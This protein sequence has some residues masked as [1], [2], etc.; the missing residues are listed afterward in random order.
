GR[1]HVR[2]RQAERDRVVLLIADFRPPMF[3]GVSRAFRSVAAAEAL[4]LIGWSAAEAGGRV[5]LLAIT[6]GEAA[7][8]RPRGRARGMLDAI[9]AMVAAHRA[10]LAA[11]R[12]GLAETPP[13][14][15]ALA[16][17]ERLAPPGAELVLA[18]GFDETGPELRDR[19]D[20][21]AR[22]RAPRLVEV[23]DAAAGALPRGRYPIRLPGGRRARVRL[24]GGARPERLSRE[25]AGR[26]ALI[27]DAGDPAEATARRIAAAFPQGRAA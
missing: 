27:V 7:V 17:V 8:A 16:P 12:R 21:L 18:S 5:G 15:A 14:D 26:Q 11:M 23:V 6:G 19:L 3:W 4:C 24:D 22:R 13:L 9:G 10:G 2:R 20:A 1:L 25:L